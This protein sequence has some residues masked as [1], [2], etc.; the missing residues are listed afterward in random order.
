MPFLSYLWVGSRKTLEV[1]VEGNVIML[2]GQLLG[3]GTTIICDERGASTLAKRGIKHI[4]K[5]EFSLK[6]ITDRFIP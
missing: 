3:K 1:D 5:E 2:E 4:V 6:Q